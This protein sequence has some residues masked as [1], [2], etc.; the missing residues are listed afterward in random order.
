MDTAAFLASLKRRASPRVE[1]PDPIATARLF[2]QLN[3]NAA[4]C[5]ALRKLLECLATM[6][7]IFREF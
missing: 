4:E 7:G 3:P 1:Y 5:G 6:Q 2:L